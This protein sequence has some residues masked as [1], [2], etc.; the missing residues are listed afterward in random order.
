MTGAT[1]AKAEARAGRSACRLCAA[2]LSPWPWEVCPWCG[3][4]GTLGLHL[5]PSDRS[6]MRMAAQ[7][8]MQKQVGVIE[9]SRM[10]WRWRRRH[11]AKGVW[12]LAQAAY[13]A[14]DP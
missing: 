2:P 14:T 12:R 9:A 4:R 6:M 13:A 1:T 5:N 7:W 11:R 8:E 3:V 10:P